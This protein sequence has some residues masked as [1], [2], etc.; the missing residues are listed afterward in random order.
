MIRFKTLEKPYENLVGRSFTITTS[1]KI[2]HS[3]VSARIQVDVGETFIQGVFF[4]SG[5]NFD[6]KSID[7]QLHDTSW[8]SFCY[9]ETAYVSYTIYLSRMKLHRLFDNRGM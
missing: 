1:N 3:H 6:N 5:Y 2:L 7:T 8:N 9:E 4:R